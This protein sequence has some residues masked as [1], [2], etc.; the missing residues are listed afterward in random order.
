MSELG[1]S[2]PLLNNCSDP[3]YK[4]VASTRHRPPDTSRVLE[5]PCQPAPHTPDIQLATQLP[6]KSFNWGF[7]C[8]VL[9]AFIG[10]PSF[11]PGK[12]Q[13]EKISTITLE[14]DYDKEETIRVRRNG[15][16]LNTRHTL[17]ITGQKSKK[18]IADNTDYHRNIWSM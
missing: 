9:S 5:C 12:L 6:V 17:F 7:G 11:I 16:Q 4:L 3:D 10:L 14:E 18:S 8:G 15:R 13:V 2:F 1:A